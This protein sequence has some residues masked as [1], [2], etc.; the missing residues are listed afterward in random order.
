MFE[1][2]LAMC[3]TNINE[4]ERNQ[5]WLELR[6]S[7]NEYH[8]SRLERLEEYVNTLHKHLNDTIS[9]VNDI[10]IYLRKRDLQCYEEMP[11]SDDEK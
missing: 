1:H 8:E 3:H 2:G 7:V 6:L 11:N 5:E 4:G 9:R 10:H